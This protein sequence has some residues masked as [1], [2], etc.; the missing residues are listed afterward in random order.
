MVPLSA[1]AQDVL[2]QLDIF[3]KKITDLKEKYCPVDNVDRWASKQR[4][5][6]IKSQVRPKT[7]SIIFTREELINI[8]VTFYSG[9]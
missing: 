8:D 2:E 6:E 1:E 4:Q 3:I 9:P 7:P 5:G